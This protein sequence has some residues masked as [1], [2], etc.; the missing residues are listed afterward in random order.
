MFEHVDKSKENSF[1]MKRQESRAVANSV[2]QNK[3]D[4]KQGFGFVDNRPETVSQMVLQGM[5]NS[6]AAE[7]SPSIQKVE[8]NTGL[9][10][11][12]KSGMENLSGMSL[13]HV[14][15]HRNSSKP[16]AVQAHAYAQGSD[17]HLASGKEKHLPHELSH[18][19]QQAQGRVKPITSVNG[20]TVNDNVGLEK[21]ADVMGVQAMQTKKKEGIGN[22]DDIS[23]AQGAVTQNKMHDNFYAG[24]STRLGHSAQLSIANRPLT[25]GGGKENLRI[26]SESTE[27]RQLILMELGQPGGTVPD[28]NPLRSQANVL[29]AGGRGDTIIW[30]S[31]PSEKVFNLD[32]SGSVQRAMTWGLTATEG[33]GGWSLRAYTAANFNAIGLAAGAA[34]NALAGIDASLDNDS[35]KTLIAI[36]AFRGPNNGA[37]AGQT[38]LD[39]GAV[40]VAVAGQAGALH[41]AGLINNALAVV[42]SVT[43]DPAEAHPNTLPTARVVFGA[44]GTVYFKGRDRNVEN[45]LVGDGGSVAHALS[46][47]GGANP[48]AARG[49][50]MHGFIAGGALGSQIAKDVGAAAAPGLTPITKTERDREYLPGW[51]GGADIPPRPEAVSAWLSAAKGALIASLTATTDLHPSNI[52][53]GGSG[54]SHL[55]DGEFLLDVTQWHNYRNMLANTGPV[56]NFDVGKFVPPWLATHMGT[57]SAGTRTLMANAVAAGFNA[58]EV[59]KTYVWQQVVA[60]LKALIA[61]P[62][63]LRV[64]P[65]GTD[66]FLGYVTTYHNTPPVGQANIVNFLW[67]DID[68]GVN[69]VINT[70]NAVAGRAVLDTNLTNGMVPLFHVRTN[71]G[72]FLLNKLTNIGNTVGGQSVD[73]LLN[74][75]GAAVSRRYGDMAALVRTQ[76]MT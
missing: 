59:D 74:L 10:D 29:A 57:I 19:V 61:T 11:N 17:I 30:P 66:V 43:A 20:M 56:V 51:L 22:L 5:A 23:N 65:L 18:V 7:Q 44:A 73:D 16:G 40:H 47:L 55:I 3:G 45:A 38:Q 9:P 42:T 28:P 50:G 33:V 6:H 70:N 12:L 1:P 31:N 14:K 72:V 67:G 34:S 58:L 32:Y 62:A 15:V 64:I 76:V 39:L 26:Q 49:V 36:R 75:A 48:N 52:K 60:P 2:V 68:N 71:D 21:E 24:E 13:D 41:G 53:A 4:V 37:M 27:V 46:S 35:N 25:V 54:K 63:L 69:A 8:N